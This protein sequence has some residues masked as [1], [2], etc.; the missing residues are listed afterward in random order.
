LRRV[1]GGR[2]SVEER[3]QLDLSKDVERFE[4]DLEVEG[5]R[6]RAGKGERVHVV[7]HSV[8]G[9]TGTSDEVPLVHGAVQ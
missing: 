9:E 1:F 4:D 3:R 5:E 7:D 6:V 8:E 2:S